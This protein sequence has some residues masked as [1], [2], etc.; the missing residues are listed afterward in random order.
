MDSTLQFFNGKELHL[1]IIRRTYCKEFQI[2]KYLLFLV[3]NVSIT[4]YYK[5]YVDG[6]FKKIKYS[7]LNLK[8]K[9]YFLLC[10]TC[11]WMA[12]T[13]PTLSDIRLI[14]YRKCPICVNNIDRFL[15]C[16][17]PF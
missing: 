11:Y 17:E 16:D 7:I 4:I 3:Y 10:G 12:S 5:K 14:K 2:I 9:K 15:I 6:H 13:V 1:K 8:Q